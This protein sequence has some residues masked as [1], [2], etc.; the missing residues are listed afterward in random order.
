MKLS[1]P[2][3]LVLAF[4]AACV[5]GLV[6]VLHDALA[7]RQQ[8]SKLGHVVSSSAA[9]LDEHGQDFSDRLRLRAHECLG[10]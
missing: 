1:L 9:S 6:M 10:R 3:R 7:R 8:I 4:L 2:T 5:A